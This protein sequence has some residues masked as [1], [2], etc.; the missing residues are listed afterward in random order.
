MSTH[1]FAPLWTGEEKSQNVWP[2][3]I[4]VSK[5]AVLNFWKRV[6]SS[7]SERESQGFGWFLDAGLPQRSV[8][9]YN[10]CL[11]PCQLVSSQ[12]RAWARYDVI[13]LTLLLWF[14][15]KYSASFAGIFVCWKVDL[16][17]Q[18]LEFLNCTGDLGTD[19]PA[20]W[21]TKLSIIKQSNLSHGLVTFE[22]TP[23]TCTFLRETPRFFWIFYFL[24]LLSRP[25]WVYVHKG[26][27]PEQ[28]RLKSRQRGIGVSWLVLDG[29]TCLPG[30]G[31][32]V[33]QALAHDL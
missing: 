11:A 33:L 9:V 1:P 21:P 26:A 32:L 15:K 23:S 24:P 18:F 8:F 5:P 4:S 2:E 30:W 13:W 7:A 20:L 3:L 28:L 19:S 29:S 22:L 27:S 17:F 16:S 6:I 10:D 14:Y 31:T 25:V 12:R